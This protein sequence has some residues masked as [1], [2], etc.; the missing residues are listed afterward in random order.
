[1]TGSCGMNGGAKKMHR[2]T[3][4]KHKSMKGG[5]SLVEAAKSLILPAILYIG[6]KF[7]QERVITRR[8][9]EMKQKRNKTMRKF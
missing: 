7:Q 2:K 6:Q 4:R 8:K 5:V 9:R 3:Q 1:M